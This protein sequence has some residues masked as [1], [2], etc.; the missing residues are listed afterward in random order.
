LASTRGDRVASARM[1]TE[2]VFYELHCLKERWSVRELVRQRGSLL[3]QRVGLSPE[4]ESV[5]ALAEAG[6]I[7]ERPRALVRDPYV[8]EFLG[9][10]DGPAVDE[11]TLEQALIDNLQHFLLELGS[12]FCFVDRQYLLSDN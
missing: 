1:A 3:Y 2:R 9:L 5:L 4:R 6:R 10:P 8:L 12:E 7:D 11:S